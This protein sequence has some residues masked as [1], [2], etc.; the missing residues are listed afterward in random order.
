MMVIFVS[1]Y[2]YYVNIVAESVATNK[3]AE[4]LTIYESSSGFYEVPMSTNVVPSNEKTV[5]NPTMAITDTLILK[6]DSSESLGLSIY[7]LSTGG[8]IL[9]TEVGNGHE[10]THD[11]KPFGIGD[12]TTI[13]TARP[14]ECSELT[15]SQCAGVSG[16]ISEKLFSITTDG[17]SIGTPVTAQI[18]ST[19]TVATSSTIIDDLKKTPAEDGVLIIASTTNPTAPEPDPITVILDTINPAESTLI[20]PA[21]DSTPEISLDSLIQNTSP[22]DEP[23]TIQNDYS[24]N[25]E[26][27]NADF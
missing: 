8:A 18:T 9:H 1:V 26:V 6:D 21:S 25:E 3:E 10:S 27:K 22:V 20:L 19:S 5:Q 15:L 23:A 14:Y 4:D 16:Y 12:F 7:K 17:V 24:N 11:V 13:K 2:M